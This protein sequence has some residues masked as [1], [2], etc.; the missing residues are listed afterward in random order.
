MSVPSPDL[1]SEG[2]QFNYKHGYVQVHRYD[3]KVKTYAI[4]SI[5]LGEGSIRIRLTGEVDFLKN[6]STDDCVMV[7]DPSGTKVGQT[8]WGKVMFP[9]RIHADPTEKYTIQFALVDTA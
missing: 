4:E 6:T 7:H 9:V 2:V 1:P 3:K 5:E 8:T